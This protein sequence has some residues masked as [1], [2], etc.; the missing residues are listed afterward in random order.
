ME[1]GFI[2]VK[3][4]GIVTYNCYALYLIYFNSGSSICLFWFVFSCCKNIS[5]PGVGHTPL[6]PALRR[7][8]QAD[9]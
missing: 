8:R 7:Q 9:F 3:A 1:D 5:E 2:K 6:I 4:E